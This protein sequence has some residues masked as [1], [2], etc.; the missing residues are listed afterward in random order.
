MAAAH[1]TGESFNTEIH[2]SKPAIL[3]HP[4]GHIN[5]QKHKKQPKFLT[6]KEINSTKNQEPVTTAQI[7]HYNRA[8]QIP[9]HN[10]INHD[11]QT[12]SYTSSDP[13]KKKKHSKGSISFFL[14]LGQ[15]V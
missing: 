9:T 12:E 8:T 2:Q 11:P 14:D 6:S 3:Q 10:L 5:L 13:I 7:R 15:T 4:K 1:S